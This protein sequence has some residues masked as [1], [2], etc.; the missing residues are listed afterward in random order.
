V[1]VGARGGGQD[2][3]T[4]SRTAAVCAAAAVV[5]LLL[6][7]LAGDWASGLALAAGLLVGSANGFLARRSLGSALDFRLSSAARLALLTAAAAGIGFLL[8]PVQVV[9]ALLGAAG[10]QVVLALSAAFEVTRP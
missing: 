7:G 3:R 4:L 1:T 9:P 2:G 6:L 5:G 10:S 8:G